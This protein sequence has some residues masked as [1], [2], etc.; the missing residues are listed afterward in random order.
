M[1]H[2]VLV[3]RTRTWFSLS[4]RSPVPALELEDIFLLALLT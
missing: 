1:Y 2:V 4:T 3:T